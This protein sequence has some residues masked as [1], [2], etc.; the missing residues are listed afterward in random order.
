[1]VIEATLNK[2]LGVFAFG[3]WDKKNRNLTFVKDRMGEKPL[4]FGRQGEVVNKVFLLGSE[5]KALKLY[6]GFAGEINCDSIALQLSHNC[7]TAPYSIYKKIYK[8]LPGH[9]L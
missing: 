7:I 1:M 6:S 2:T 4:Y 9:Y 3:V 5:L 8:R